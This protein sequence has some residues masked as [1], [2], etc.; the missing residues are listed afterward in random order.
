MNE[1]DIRDLKRL[2][3]FGVIFLFVSAICSAAQLAVFLNIYV[4]YMSAY[5]TSAAA[6]SAE[7]ESA[8]VQELID[9]GQH[10]EALMRLTKL[11]KAR[12]NDGRIYYLRGKVYF[13]TGKYQEAVADLEKSQ[14]LEPSYGRWTKPLLKEIQQKYDAVLNTIPTQPS[15][16]AQSK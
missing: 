16:A 1:K 2:G 10:D 15:S 5:K 14:L 8:Q 4:P 7:A 6:T 13:Q 9:R 12:P 11:E 3:R